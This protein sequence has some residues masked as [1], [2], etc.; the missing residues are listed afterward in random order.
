MS[1]IPFFSNCEGY[2]HRIIFYD[3]FEYDESC[4][5]PEEDKIVVV[6]PIPSTGIKPTADD[7]NLD[8]RCRLDETL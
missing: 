2:D 7:C 8:L 3:I 5:L 1:W 6:N 4:T